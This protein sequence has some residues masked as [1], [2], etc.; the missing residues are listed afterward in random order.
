MPWI[1]CATRSLLAVRGPGTRLC[2]CTALRRDVFTTR[3]GLLSPEMKTATRPTPRTFRQSL[4]ALRDDLSV[5][6]RSRG[7][8][9]HRFCGLGFFQ[10]GRAGRLT[11]WPRFII[12]LNCVRS[13][14]GLWR[15]RSACATAAGFPRAAAYD[16]E[17]CCEP[18]RASPGRCGWSVFSPPSRCGWAYAS[19]AAKEAHDA[20]KPLA[21][22][23]WLHPTDGRS[24]CGRIG[25]CGRRCGSGAQSTGE[26]HRLDPS[27]ARRSR[28]AP[29]SAAARG[30]G[31]FDSMPALVGPGDAGQRPL[32]AD[33]RPRG[34]SVPQ[35]GGPATD[36][37]S[38]AKDPGFS[39]TKAPTVQE[40]AASSR[41]AAPVRKRDSLARTG[42]VVCEESVPSDGAAGYKVTATRHTRP[43]PTDR[44][45]TGWTI[46]SA[47]IPTQR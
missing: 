26:I 40:E 23:Q 21:V 30:C 28:A 37:S 45:A 7:A 19:A 29:A 3:C 22:I 43:R 15:A 1:I 35:P 11:G 6:C 24:R 27:E 34:Q 13:V 47:R 9:A 44:P 17:C 5:R 16:V 32:P 42:S 18:H 46:K 38:A 4:V 14:C 2:C 31:R 33:Y 25:V 12:T 36:G 10:V 41:A 8:F 20:Q 39:P